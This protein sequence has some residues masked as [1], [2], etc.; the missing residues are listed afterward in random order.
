MEDSRV[1]TGALKWVLVP[2]DLDTHADNGLEYIVT[3]IE[4]WTEQIVV[5]AHCPAENGHPMP[6]LVLEDHRGTHYVCKESGRA[7]PRIF[8]AF[9]P[10]LPPNVRSLHVRSLGED[11]HVKAAPIV[12][13]V[14]AGNSSGFGPALLAE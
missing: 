10:A 11:R 2:Q 8:Q 5:I 7:G 6:D 13:A 9:K 14:P 4:V 1:T 12:V 3:A